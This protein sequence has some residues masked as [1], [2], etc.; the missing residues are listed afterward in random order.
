MQM[1]MMI[2]G[3]FSALT[4]MAC[5]PV[6]VGTSSENPVNV[7]DSGRVTV[8]AGKTTYVVKTYPQSYFYLDN[9]LFDKAVPIDFSN[10]NSAGYV[11]SQEV[12]VDWMNLQPVSV[13]I[14]WK[15]AV[16][17]AKLVRAINQ[18]TTNS[19]LA[20]AVE[21]NVYFYNRVKVVYAITAPSQPASEVQ[22][23]TFTLS[24]PQ[25]KVPTALYVVAQ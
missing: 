16:S 7:S 25:N 2:L 23:L 3:A 20:Y 8:A 4:L 9:A 19:N 22:P 11:N 14:G 15:I 1:K 13:P 24:T 6:S 10:R 17:E 21:T 18:T 5:V 12:K